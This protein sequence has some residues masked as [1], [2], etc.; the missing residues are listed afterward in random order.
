MTTDPTATGTFPTWVRTSTAGSVA[1]PAP[2]PS[3]ESFPLSASEPL[4]PSLPPLRSSDGRLELTADTLTVNGQRFLLLELE[5]VELTPVRW[6]LW[7]LL[8]GFALAGFA[9]AFLQNWLRTMPA[10][11]GLAASALLFVYGQRGTNRLRLHRLGRE[12]VHFALPGEPERWQ[13]L[14][15]ETNRRIRRRHDEAAAAAAAALLPPPTY[16]EL[17]PGAE[18]SA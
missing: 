4:E 10:M 18:P 17:P 13:Q 16:E 15:R 11:L 3:E 1:P 6:L 9:L 8:G 2:M 5:A 7:Y 14:A 12:A